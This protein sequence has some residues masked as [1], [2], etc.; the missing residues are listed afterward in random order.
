MPDTHASMVGL[1]DDSGKPINW[2]VTTLIS[3]IA[4]VLTVLAVVGTAAARWERLDTVKE[5]VKELKSLTP[6]VTINEAKTQFIAEQVVEI[7]KKVDRLLER[8]R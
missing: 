2:K 1:V 6:R 4:L 3:L 5:D 8:R 7:N